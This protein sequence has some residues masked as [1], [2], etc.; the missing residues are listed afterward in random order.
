M[1]IHIVVDSI[2]VV[3]Q[4]SDVMLGLLH[5]DTGLW[6]GRDAEEVPG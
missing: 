5:A 3:A 6:L 1:K 2:S 4:L